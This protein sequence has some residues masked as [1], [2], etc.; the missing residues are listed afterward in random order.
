MHMKRY[1]GYFS[2]AICRRISDSE[3]IEMNVFTPKHSFFH[4]HTKIPIVSFTLPWR[5]KGEI[6]FSRN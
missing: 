2:P 4:P 5:Y 1:G 3:I 6:S